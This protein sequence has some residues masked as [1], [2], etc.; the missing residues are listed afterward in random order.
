MNVK[1]KIDIKQ[2][3]FTPKRTREKKEQTNFHWMIL[4][5]MGSKQSWRIAFQK[6][7]PLALLSG[8][9]CMYIALLHTSLL[10]MIST[11]FYMHR[12]L[13]IKSFPVNN[14]KN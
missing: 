6:G 13:A 4:K 14:K 1:K 7:T 9:E 3:N 8:D 10:H 12:R 5:E 11:F 2:L